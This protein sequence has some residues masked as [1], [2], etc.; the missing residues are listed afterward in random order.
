MDVG[1]GFSCVFY[2][3]LGFLGFG[4]FGVFVGFFWVVVVVCFFSNWISLHRPL[5]TYQTRKVKKFACRV[6]PRIFQATFQIWLYSIYKMCTI[7]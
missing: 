2:V 7:P 1:F 6:M 5:M 3:W 4:G